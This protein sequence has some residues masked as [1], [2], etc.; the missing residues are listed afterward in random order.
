MTKELKFEA[1]RTIKPLYKVVVVGVFVFWGLM[2]ANGVLGATL[3][4]TSCEPPTYSTGYLQDQD[5]WLYSETHMSVVVDPLAREGIQDIESTIPS[6]SVIFMKTNGTP[7]CEGSQGFWFKVVNP[8][9][10]TPDNW[11]QFDLM[12]DV[13]N[14][15]FVI[16]VGFPTKGQVFYYAHNNPTPILLGNYILDTWFSID[17]EWNCYNH[18]VRYNYWSQGWTEWESTQD[19]GGAGTKWYGENHYQSGGFGRIF[20]DFIAESSLIG[21]CS[22]EYCYLCADWSS[23]QNWTNCIWSYTYNYCFQ[24]EYGCGLG[25][26]EQKCYFCD[27]EESCEA[28][29]NCYWHENYCFYGVGECAAGLQ[30]QFCENEI[31]CEN[32]GGYWYDDHCWEEPKP[33]IGSWGDWYDDYGDYETPAAMVNTLATGSQSFFESIGGFLTTFNR[34]FDL[35]AAYQNGKDFGEVIPTARGYLAT[36]DDFV[37]FLPVGTFFMFV[38]MFMLAVGVFRIVRAL[39]QLVKFW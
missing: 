8:S 36:L 18:Q 2:I 19:I 13:G 16:R 17:I 6:N 5:G 37:G 28:V 9:A 1:I 35:A 7:T 34:T 3:F 30:L 20:V 22:N 10:V 25:F 26:G 29:E 12:D 39:I 14:D 4:E 38:L 21:S 11:T 23:C 27:T 24:K 32:A 31:D 33:I 15:I